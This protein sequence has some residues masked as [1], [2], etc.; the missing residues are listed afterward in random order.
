MKQSQYTLQVIEPSEGYTLTNEEE[1]LFSKKIFLAVT[2][3]ADNY[4]EV[5]D[6]YATQ[7]QAFLEEERKKKE[8][9]NK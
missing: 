1:T 6:E 2:D 7:R 5:T 3:S 4:H 8:E 9:E